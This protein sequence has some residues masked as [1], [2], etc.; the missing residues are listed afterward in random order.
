MT[1]FAIS[2][3]LLIG[4]LSSSIWVSALWN[5][6]NINIQALSTNMKK[7]NTTLDKIPDSIKLEAF[8]KILSNIDKLIAQVD[9]RKLSK[10]VKLKLTTQYKVVKENI[11]NRIEKLDNEDDSFDLWSVLSGVTLSNPVNKPNQDNKIESKNTTIITNDPAPVIPLINTSSNASVVQ[12]NIVS[13]WSVNATMPVVTRN[14]KVIFNPAMQPP[15]GSRILSPWYFDMSGVP[16]DNFLWAFS[17]PEGNREVVTSYKKLVFKNIWTANLSEVIKSRFDIS[18]WVL[19]QRYSWNWCIHLID[20]TIILDGCDIFWGRYNTDFI[21]KT[22]LTSLEN[23]FDK[24]IQLSFVPEESIIEYNNMELHRVMTMDINNI[25]NN[26]I[27]P[28]YTITLNSLNKTIERINPNTFK[29]KLSNSNMI[30]MTLNTINLGFYISPYSTVPLNWGFCIRP[31]GSNILCDTQ[32]NT[33]SVNNSSQISFPITN[34][35]IIIPKNGNLEYEVLLNGTWYTNDY[36]PT[37]GI[38]SRHTYSVGNQQ[39][40][41]VFLN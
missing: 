28:I 12:N 4:I 15:G 33:N 18:I 2:I 1:K 38:S 6:T 32:Y 34:E 22:K 21:I 26:T 37:M 27:F 11:E 9:K 17:F 20:N 19:W 30:D 8:N 40:Q 24:T 39:F 5:N 23:Y 35:N 29:L 41:G 36:L 3:I 14:Y 7:L 31:I 16:F 25:I 13:T 10:K